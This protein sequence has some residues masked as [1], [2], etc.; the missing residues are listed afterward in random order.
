MPSPMPGGGASGA[1]AARASLGAQHR[2]PVSLCRSLGP[3]SGV[4]CPEQKWPWLELGDCV[5]VF[6]EP[7]WAQRSRRKAAP[8]AGS[9]G[10]GQ[11]REV[12]ERL[13]YEIT[14]G[15]GVQEDREGRFECLMP[16][17]L[18]ETSAFSCTLR[19]ST[20]VCSV[21]ISCWLLSDLWS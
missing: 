12:L 17:N 21:R 18:H 7:F 5:P 19:C 8:A 2:K 6:A 16:Q 20:D 15:T 9:Q 11:G 10:A 13:R 1:S 3:V 4:C 14:W